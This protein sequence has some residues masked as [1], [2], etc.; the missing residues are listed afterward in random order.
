MYYEASDK[1]LGNESYIF[2]P[3]KTPSEKENCL[4][5]YLS[6]YSNK[7]EF[8]GSITVFIRQG[9]TTVKQIFSHSGVFPINER[10]WREINVDIHLPE[11]GT[12]QVCCFS[13]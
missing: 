11:I 6:M 9:L 1:P 5:F 13:S 3:A 2:I 10:T 8:M 12:Y 7:P 4:Q